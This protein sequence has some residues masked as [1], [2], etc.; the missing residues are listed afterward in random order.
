MS[1][2][3][4]FE[5]HVADGA[6][7]FAE[8]LVIPGAALLPVPIEGWPEK[9]WPGTL[10]FRIAP[11]GFPRDYLTRFRS[12]S[13]KHLDSRQ[14]IPL[15]Q[16]SASLII[17][18]TLPPTKDEPERGIAQ[19]WRATIT[20]AS[21]PATQCWVLRR[22]GSGYSTV[23]ETVAERA[24]RAVLNAPKGVATPARLSLEGEWRV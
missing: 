16:L 11:N 4:H 14:F 10:N 20:V 21:G 15:A 1:V 23:L 18:N 7:K 6:H 12:A 24:L 22:I 9:L 19:I 13:V 5:G 3:L 8:Q 17:G 2:T